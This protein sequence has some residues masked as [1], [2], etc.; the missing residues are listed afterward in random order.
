MKVLIACEESQEVCKAFREL[1]HEAFSCDLQPCSGDHPEWHYQDSIWHVLGKPGTEYPMQWDLIIAHPPCTYL[2][3]S[4]VRWLYN[5]DGSINTERWDNMI[6][7][8]IFFRSLLYSNCDKICIENP[9]M[10][11]HARFFIGRKQDQTI[12][13]YEFGHPESK[14]T[15]LWLKGLPKLKP[16]NILKKPEVGYWDN[17]TASGQNKLAPSPER[18]KIRSKTYSGIAKAMAE[19]WS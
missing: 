11:K 10:H 4:G 3:N 15:C 2:S 6:D 5:K 8:A 12:Q 7:G 19:Q 16:T 17:Q 1:G 13:P 18:A 14:R 9:V